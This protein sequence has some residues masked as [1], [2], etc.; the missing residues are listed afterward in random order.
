MQNLKALN[1]NPDDEAQKEE[2]K[3]IDQTK[4]EL[5]AMYQRQVMQQDVSIV[6]FIN[7]CIKSIIDNDTV[8]TN[9]LRVTIKTLIKIFELASETKH[10][11]NE[12]KN[13]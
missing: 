8:P 7:L 1:S 6:P 11:K 4:R 9:L 3:L 10:L 13:G 12:E 2:N 5:N